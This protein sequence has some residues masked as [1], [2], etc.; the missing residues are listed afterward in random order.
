MEPLNLEGHSGTSVDID[1]CPQCQAFWF[2]AQESLKLP[3][4]STLRLFGMI[5]EAP[6]RARQKLPPVLRC[7]RCRAQLQLTNDFQRSTAFRYW[8][9]PSNHGRFITYFEFLREKDFIRPLSQQQ[10]DDL[11]RNVQSVNCSNC[12]GAVEL[13][14]GAACEH[15]G[16]P[17]SM[18]DLK[19]AETVVNQ[20]KRAAEPRP[21]DPALP[22]ELARARRE[23]EAAFPP[24]S[25]WSADS[26]SSFGLVEALVKW[27]KNS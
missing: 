12:G 6:S 14:R 26:S 16:T 1:V 7:T 24:A 3:P 8:K 13:S 25:Q 20:L 11:R 19:Q 22:L 9:C 21:I 18:L 27:L 2:D 4:A 17:L 10:I 23:V 15:C 5:G